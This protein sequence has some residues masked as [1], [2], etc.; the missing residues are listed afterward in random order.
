M[1]PN[2]NGSRA[3][4]G[5]P[6]ACSKCSEEYGRVFGREWSAGLPDMRVELAETLGKLRR[7]EQVLLRM[8]MSSNENVRL[9][10]ELVQEAMASASGSGGVYLPGDLVW[11]RTK[12]NFS[13]PGIVRS[14]WHGMFT[15]EHVIDEG[16][17]SCPASV[18]SPRKG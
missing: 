6:G 13:W 18:M 9:A 17:V 14:V 2:E 4:C 8:S 12:N 5:G 7:M 3:R 16:R 11:V 15:V 1:V 10:A